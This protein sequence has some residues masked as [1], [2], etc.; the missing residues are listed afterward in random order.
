MKVLQMLMFLLQQISANEDKCYRGDWFVTAK[1][2]GTMTERFCFESC[3]ERRLDPDRKT[4][5]M[6]IMSIKNCRINGKQCPEDPVCHKKKREIFQCKCRDS[7]IVTL[8][9]FALSFGG[10]FF[11]FIKF[12]IYFLYKIRKHTNNPDSI[13]NCARHKKPPRILLKDLLSQ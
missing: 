5:D 9:L 8:W 7:R 4:V 1:D 10:G 3:E 12:M 11:I 13:F 6:I 2:N